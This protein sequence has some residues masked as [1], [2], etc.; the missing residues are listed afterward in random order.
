MPEAIRRVPHCSHWG[1]YTLLVQGQQVVGVEPFEGDPHPS[2]IIRSVAAWGSSH[3]RVLQPM[4]NPAW[5]EAA[6]AGRP[7]TATERQTRGAAKLVRIEPY[8]GN[9]PIPAQLYDQRLQEQTA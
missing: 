1:A 5:L 8:T 7:T 4:A 9:A 6:R 3:R 2:A